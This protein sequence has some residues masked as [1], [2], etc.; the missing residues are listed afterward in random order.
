MWKEDVFLIIIILMIIIIF[1]VSYLKYMMFVK[2]NVNVN[3][4]R[5][6]NRCQ[7]F[8][9]NVRKKNVNKKLKRK[10]LLLDK[11]EMILVVQRWYV[12][13]YWKDVRI[14]KRNKK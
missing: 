8:K 13:E 6:K 7:Y 2:Y 3:L 14:D 10:R 9:E 5:L 12:N 4:E 1:V 11:R